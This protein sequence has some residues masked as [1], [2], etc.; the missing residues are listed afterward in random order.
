MCEMAVRGEITDIVTRWA[1]AV[2]SESHH[3]LKFR[4]AEVLGEH[5][6]TIRYSWEPL[7]ELKA[8]AP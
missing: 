6:V 3:H 7:A 2:A 5:G 8:A 4:E 1:A